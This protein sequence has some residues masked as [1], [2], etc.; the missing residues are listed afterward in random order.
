MISKV[1]SAHHFSIISS[2]EFQN[3]VDILGKLSILL[4]TEFV[5]LGSEYG[6][7]REYSIIIQVRLREYPLYQKSS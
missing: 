3:K 1:V 7:L 2:N 4:L 5:D 6:N